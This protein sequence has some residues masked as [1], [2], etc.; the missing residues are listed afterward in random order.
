MSVLLSVDAKLTHVSTMNPETEILGFS[1]DTTT[2]NTNVYGVISAGDAVG[3]TTTITLQNLTPKVYTLCYDNDGP[4]STA[5]QHLP[6]VQLTVSGVSLFTAA[7][8]F[9]RVTGESTT[10]SFALPSTG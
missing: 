8:S 3:T 2:T 4:L 9:V 10:F 7:S 1:C 6:N 5:Y